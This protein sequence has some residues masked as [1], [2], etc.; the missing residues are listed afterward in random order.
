MCLK[1][2]F[3]EI[4]MNK[5]LLLLLL[6]LLLLL[7]LLLLSLL[8][9]LL[10]LFLVLRPSISSLLQSATSGYYKVRLNKQP[11]EW[12]P[13]T[14]RSSNCVQPRQFFFSSIW[15]DLRIASGYLA[16]FL[17]RMTWNLMKFD[18]APAFQIRWIASAIWAIHQRITLLTPA[19]GWIRKRAR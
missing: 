7:L 10:L 11:N 14:T 6:F 13:P 15:T 17:R 8:L 4:G 2:I 12:L 19:H 5:L 16:N 18:P 9:L 3:H 1:I